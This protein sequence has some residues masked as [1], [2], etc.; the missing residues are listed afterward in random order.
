MQL[1]THRFPCILWK[2]RS[3]AYLYADTCGNP[4]CVTAC[5]PPLYRGG[6]MCA[7]FCCWCAWI[8]VLQI[9]SCDVCVVGGVMMDMHFVGKEELCM[10][11]SW[12][13]WKSMLCNCTLLSSLSW[14]RHVCMC[15]LLVCV[16]KY[17]AVCK[18]RCVCGWWCDDGYAFCGKR[19]VVHVCV[20]TPVDI[21][22]V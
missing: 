13:L 12:H 9:V 20:L 15:L 11:V 14:W 6:I 3:C 18:S 4:S 7:C 10:F 17:V 21:L 5:C 2:K 19:G 1:L 22:A 8:N 16:N